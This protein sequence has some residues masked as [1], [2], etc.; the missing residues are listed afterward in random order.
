LQFDRS[1]ILIMAQHRDPTPTPTRT[2]ADVLREDTSP[3]RALRSVQQR[4]IATVCLLAVGG[5]IFL[6]AAA[7]RSN[8]QF[9]QWNSLVIHTRDVLRALDDFGSAMK[10]GQLSAVEYYTNGS[11]SQTQV[12]DAS[13]AAAHRA[14]GRVRSLT[15]DN[16]TQQHNLDTL[17]PLGE[18][19]FDLL[20][21][22]I[23]L[24]REGK[25]GPDAL[26]SVT[27]D[28]RKI[29]PPLAGALAA[30][31]KEE[32]R[33]LELRSAEAALAARRARLLQLN[34]GIFATALVLVVFVLFLRENSIRA[35]GES[36]LRHS[37]AQLRSTNR[38]LEAFSYS[39]SHDLRAPLRGIDGFSQALLEDHAAQLN[40]DGK[41]LLERVRAA[42][43]RM[44]TL[45]DDLIGRSRIARTEMERQT[46]DL[47]QLA[48]S[49]ADELQGTQTR[50]AVEFAIMPG[51]HA[52]GDARLMRVVFQNLL[53][54]SYKFTSKRES[55]RIEFGRTNENGKSA[56]FVKDNGAGFD[57]EYSSRLF[58]AFQRLHTAAEF[59]GTGIGLA[60]VQRIIHLHGGEI[61]AQ[62]AEGR[63][64]TFF[65]TL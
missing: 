11:E 7:Y 21:R 47:S 4:L 10:S 36:R 58:G 65:F 18:Q 12:F 44:G 24:H 30:M 26:K 20:G 22:V 40:E 51:L 27:E 37:N 9:A 61:W 45:I 52:N 63:G 46:V 54:N 17:I 53:S 64:A 8:T 19:G 29:S 32:N 31:I 43:Q 34:G 23:A 60:T 2:V 59:P 28:A 56:Y 3:W 39:V 33:L 38:E 41:K 16:T 25:S 15:S 5:L 48:R 14:L 50:H 57:P 42:V 62:G 49:V 35:A 55:A 6:F 1:L 13:R